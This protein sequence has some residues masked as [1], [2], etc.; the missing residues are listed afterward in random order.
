MNV[1]ERIQIVLDAD[2][3]EQQLDKYLSDLRDSLASSNRQ[4]VSLELLVLV[5]LVTYHLVSFEGLQISSFQGVPL[6]S[7]SLFQRVFVVDPAELLAA[8]AS[9]GY[10]RRCQRE[11]Y[12]YLTIS[13]YRALAKSGLHELRLPADYL[14]GL[15]YMR[16]VGGP[17]G[18]GLANVVAGLS[19]VVFFA[20]PVA[21]VVY[22]AMANVGAYGTQDTL[23]LAA[24]IVAGVLSACGLAISALAG[25]VRA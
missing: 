16:E 19:Y 6:P 24:S 17:I 18:G 23:C 12:D 4:F 22:V 15:F 3:N 8:V 11:V 21:Y 1:L 10:L 7:S 13:R 25:A 5:S 9:I 2:A 20:G 14:L